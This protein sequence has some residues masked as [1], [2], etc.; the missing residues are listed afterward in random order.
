MIFFKSQLTPTDDIVLINYHRKIE[1]RSHA[2]PI[3]FTFSDLLSIRSYINLFSLLLYV[4][5][6]FVSSGQVV[7]DLSKRLEIAFN[8]SIDE[9]AGFFFSVTWGDVHHVGFDHDGAVAGRSRV[10][11][12]D[13]SVIGEAVVPTYD[14]EADDVLFL[15][16]NLEA[17]CAVGGG[18]AGDNVDLTEGADFAVADEEVAALDEVLV[19][20]WVVEA[21][22]D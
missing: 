17:L 4:V 9:H 2:S 1:Y 15:V 20:L 7:G 8:N 12:G 18:E 10:E 14:A 3:F 5:Y 13:G 6:S 16:Q 19:G 11:G 21:A 22:D